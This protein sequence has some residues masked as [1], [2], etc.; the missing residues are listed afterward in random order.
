VSWKGPE[1]GVEVWRRSC[2]EP[3]TCE[4]R[5]VPGDSSAESNA[6]SKNSEGLTAR[7]KLND[8]AQLTRPQNLVSLTSSNLLE[9]E[10]KPWLGVEAK[11]GIANLVGT[12]SASITGTMAWSIADNA[13]GKT[14]YGLIA[15]AG[16]A[17]LT[18]GVT[19]FATKGSTEM[20]LLDP[21]H[22]TTGLADLAWGGVDALAAVG[23]VKAEEAFS[24]TW[25]TQL[26]KSSGMHLS[27]ELLEQQGKKILEG[28]LKQR[29]LH[30]TLRGV[31][32]GTTGTLLWSTPH[33]LSNNFDKLNTLDGWKKTGLDVGKNTLFGGAFGGILF[34]GGTALW[35]ARELAGITKAA[36]LGK[37]GRYSLDVYHFN[38]GH[39]SVL[40]DR[41]TLQQVAGKAEELRAASNKSGTS[42]VVLDLGD[43]HSG[44][45]AA[46]V[47]NTGELEQRVIQQHLK[48]DAS[49]PGNH[50]VDTGMRGY[51]ADVKKWVANMTQ[52]NSELQASSGRELPG[53]AANVQNLLEPNF[54]GS[55]GIYK[56]YRVFVDPKTGDKVAM[57]GLVTDALQG[58]TPK[59]LDVDLA[60]A[61]NRFGKMS[62]SEM[63]DAAASDPAIKSLFESVQKASP[64]ANLNA[65]VESVVLAKYTNGLSDEGV[66]AM[67]NL[68]QVA[69]K[70]PEAKL[71]EIAAQNP[72]NKLV[73][74]LA[75][76][77]P[78]KR[79]ADLRQVMVSD[80]QKAL[81]QAVNAAKAEGV[82]KVI[83]LSHMG[84]AED[85]KLAQEGPRVA[86]IIGGHSHDLEPLP[87]F[88]RNKATG[89]DVLVTQA[90]HDYGW[91]G[92]TKL[93][94]NK[95]GSINRYLSSGKM[96]VIDQNVA[97]MQSAQDAI[98]SHMQSTGAGQTL[99]KQMS[100]RHPIDVATEVP[101]N[102][103]RGN[104]GKQTPLANLLVN[105]FKEGGDKA[106]PEVN[107]ARATQ[108]LA[109][110][111][112]SVDAVLVQSGGIRA[113]LP[114]GQVDELT[115]QTMFMNQPTLVEMSGEQIQKA[116]SY[117]VHD[118]PAAERPQNLMQQAWNMI[119]SF[120][121]EVPPL[122]SA[123]VSGKNIIAGQLRFNV[124]RSMPS[125]D[126]VS[127]VEI[128][129]KSLGQYVPIDPA[130][131]Y[132]VM[133]VTHLL[134]RWGN[135]PLIPLKQLSGSIENLGPQYWVYGG[136]MEPT[137]V[138]IMMSP[139]DLPSS[140]SRNFLLDFLSKNSTGGSFR[141]PS[142][143]MESPM[144]DLSPD[145][146]IP[147]VR[148]DLGTAATLGAVS[149][150][151]NK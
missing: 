82:D 76:L 7:Q 91:L 111:G 117:G 75:S 35:N 17:I 71:A 45:A 80:P 19:R 36:V 103:I 87:L 83:V 49:V 65:S 108:G 28:D 72:G 140:S 48:V 73:S 126:R 147:S 98:L 92:E 30:N 25:K 100:Q 15:K 67:K 8:E 33:E 85:L 53:V 116:L 131:K 81:E 101:L 55:Q 64:Q 61:M 16:A 69:G 37:Q 113:G 115:L 40:G 121:R 22:R 9:T 86:A 74:D 29:I 88:A 78:E 123:D 3:Y 68:L 119:S 99:L 77:Y 124:D 143:L 139:S 138:S 125:Y 44:N 27:Q 34:G 47:S 21:G 141:M 60:V 106:L 94:F 109:K 46:T 95:D 24:R 149:G 31:V 5:N 70:H 122:Q 150:K 42:S 145:A 93:V 135:T 118:L 110:L 6:E 4:D 112:D 128:F 137:A 11:Q 41:S 23:A 102:G 120:R 38:D 132:T 136:K 2:A 12:M 57:V 146:W 144:R 96:H 26:G 59:L 50:I 90:G 129:D 20:L 51:P 127:A 107:A 13:L 134:G 105:A 54:I 133:T 56:P 18:G 130:K 1:G 10:N 52:I 148:P 97:P 142:S 114:A 79:M 66:Q 39:S 43:A 84:R 62:L 104:Y 151:G 14:R 32:G 63:K 89:S 58:A